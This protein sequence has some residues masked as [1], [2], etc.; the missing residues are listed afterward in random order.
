MILKRFYDNRLAQASYLYGC[1]QSGEAVVID[2]CRDVD[3][4][5]EAAEAEG[6][7][8]VGVTETHIHADFASGSLELAERTGATLYLSDEGDE[9]WKYA[10]AD[11]PNVR[12]IRDG[13][14]IRIGALRLD[15]V[16]TPGHT[17]EHLAFILTDEA[18][19]TEPCCAF[20]GDFLFA[21]DVGRP[22][23]LERAANFEGTMEKGARV[24]YH[25][26]QK[27]RV[28][29][30]HMLVWPG[31]GAGS[32]CGKSLGGVPVTTLGYE[33]ATN[34]AFQVDAEEAFVE[35]VLSGQPDPPVYF[36]EMKRLNK[37][38][39]DPV[40]PLGAP[41]RFGARRLEELLDQGQIVL[42]TRPSE[43]VA[44]SLAP[45]ALHVPLG[46]SFTTWSGWLLPY[47]Q[48]I[49]LIAAD[50]AAAT[51]ARR[52]LAMIGLD[53]VRAWFGREAVSGLGARL[54]SVPQITA[55][56]VLG[57]V[58]A[59]EVTLLD[60]RFSSE[61]EE[62]AV[63]GSIHIPLGQLERRL[64]EV[65]KG[66]PLVVH[67]AGGVRSPMAVSLL[68]KHG[69]RDAANLMGGYAAIEEPRPSA[70]MAPS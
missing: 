11:R 30:A 6:M 31:H 33:C 3:Q 12:L 39:P 46:K 4:Y 23:L 56:E 54:E 5:L 52:D 55:D 41:I 47:D 60:V 36:K 67:C 34:W 63:A 49:Y 32:A 19:S 28:F 57:K 38:G 15:V 7:R 35:D 9:M 1:P 24:L 13:D 17:P 20:T 21:G 53:D 62:G 26:I 43:E 70:S 48:P 59:G 2:P 50:E 40:G 25:T 10:F 66:K 14:Q 16:H 29:P 18:A 8:I 68:R 58:E 45:G 64:A 51:E 44:T 61:V 22:D 27:F 37:A 65:P 42:D 69:V